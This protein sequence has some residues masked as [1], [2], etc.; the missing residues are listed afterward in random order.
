MW[1]RHILWKLCGLHFE[2]RTRWL[3]NGLQCFL[4][5]SSVHGGCHVLS[6]LSLIIISFLHHF[7]G[8]RQWNVIGG[9]TWIFLRTIDTGHLFMYLLVICTL[10]LEKGIRSN[11]STQNPR[12][13]SVR[14]AH[15]CKCRDHMSTSGPCHMLARHCPPGFLSFSL[16]LLFGF[17]LC[18][19]LFCFICCVDAG[20]LVGGKLLT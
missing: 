17:L 4:L 19:A 10:S 11:P 8:Y 5:P 9:F 6:A 16:L 2:K 15:M 1:N 20:F 14:G 18:F 3:P 13:G 12:C 7:S